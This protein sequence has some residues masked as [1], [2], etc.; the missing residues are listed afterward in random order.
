MSMHLNRTPVLTT[1]VLG[2]VACEESPT[3]P[4]LPN[5]AYTQD[6]VSTRGVASG[7]STLFDEDEISWKLHVTPAA[8]EA[9]D[10]SPTDVVS[11]TDPGHLV[12]SSGIRRGVGQALVTLTAGQLEPGVAATLWAVVFNNP[13]ACVG[14]CDDPDLFENPATKAD[15]MF[16]AGAVSNGLGVVR[17]TGR[18]AEDRTD[19]SIMP[20]FGLPAWG[21]VDATRAEIHLVVRTH[22]SVIPG[23]RQ[24]QT[25]TFNGGCT[26]MGSEFGAPGPNECI[27]L[28]YASHYAN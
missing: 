22:G 17:Y 19:E 7:G 20:L 8:P 18:I 6:I 9:S 15:L 12:G 4:T 2:L 21:V 23:L 16:V 10:W 5:Q 14:E 27:D 28:Y 26:G 13:S 25:T 11:F 3:S 1:L 24:A